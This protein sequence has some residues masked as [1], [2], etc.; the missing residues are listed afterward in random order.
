MN[1]VET[2]HGGSDT[3]STWARIQQSFLPHT[4]ISCDSIE[5]DKINRAVSCVSAQE[6][7]DACLYQTTSNLRMEDLTQYHHYVSARAGIDT[8]SPNRVR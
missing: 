8:A 6:T 3:K 7:G 4:E 5:L 1:T 2:S